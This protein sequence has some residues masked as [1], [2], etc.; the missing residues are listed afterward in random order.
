MPLPLHPLSLLHTLPPVHSLSLPPPPPPHLTPILHYP[1][2]FPFFLP[3]GTP[4]ADPA[5]YL[6]QGSSLTPADMAK[7]RTS[8][9][10]L[11]QWLDSA[12]DEDESEEED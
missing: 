12:E 9:D 11:V 2:N 10:P 8:C 7:L 3:P 5:S 4:A 1:R 6:P